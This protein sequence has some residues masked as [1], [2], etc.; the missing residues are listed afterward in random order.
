MIKKIIKYLTRILL[1]FFILLISYFVIA[2]VLSILSTNLKKIDC[3]KSAQIFVSTNGVHLDII[4][5]INKLPIA[6]QQELNLTKNI[7]FVSFGWGDKGFYLET[8]TWN[9]LKFS[10][11]INA[12]FLKSETAMHVTNYRNKLNSWHTIPICDSQL[13]LL[14]QYIIESFLRG[15]DDQLLI[16]PNA[17]YTNHDKFYEANGSYNLINTCNSWVNKGLKTAE[18]KTSIWSP[19]DKGVLFHME[20]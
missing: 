20:N 12:I 18:I 15:G 7:K 11:A 6:F 17:G 19:F 10:T 9:D 8:P 1:L 3:N 14:T 13:E 2:F 16:I 5:P 4:I